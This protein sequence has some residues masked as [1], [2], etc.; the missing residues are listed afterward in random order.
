MKNEK[1]TRC[2]DPVVRYCQGCRYGWVQYPSWVETKEDLA[3]CCFESGCM[4]GL[5]NDEHTE[6]ELAEFD[7]II[8][9]W[10]E[11]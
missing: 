11:V 3:G 9:K 8:D 10:N 2:I 5:E 1:P 7:R 4:Y 6:E